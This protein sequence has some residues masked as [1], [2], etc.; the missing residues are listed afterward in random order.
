MDALRVKPVARQPDLHEGFAAPHELTDCHGRLP[1]ADLVVGD[2]HGGQH[3]RLRCAAAE[4]DGALTAEPVMVQ[5]NA[6]QVAMHP[7]HLRNGARCTVVD[8]AAVQGQHAEVREPPSGL[9][10]HP[11]PVR[12]DLVAR[13]AELLQSGGL[14]LPEGEAAGGSQAHVVSCQDLEGLELRK[15]GHEQLEP[16]VPHDRVLGDVQG[17]HPGFI[18]QPLRRGLHAARTAP[19]LLACWRRGL[20]AQRRAR[21][22]G[23]RVPSFGQLARS[24]GIQLIGA[25]DQGGDLPREARAALAPQREHQ[26]GDAAG[27]YAVLREVHTLA[28]VAQ[29]NQEQCQLPREVVDIFQQAL[30]CS[31]VRPLVLKDVSEVQRRCVPGGLQERGLFYPAPDLPRVEIDGRH[32]KPLEGLAAHA[33]QDEFRQEVVWNWLELPPVLVFVVDDQVPERRRVLED[34]DLFPDLASTEV[35]EAEVPDAR[36]LTLP[37]HGVE[38]LRQEA[39]RHV[40]RLGADGDELLVQGVVVATESFH[41]LQALVH[42]LRGIGPLAKLDAEERCVVARKREVVGARHPRQRLRRREVVEPREGLQAPA[43]AVV[44]VV[45]VAQDGREAQERERS[46]QRVCPAVV[47]LAEADVLCLRQGVDRL[48]VELHPPRGASLHS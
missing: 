47:A 32:C 44:V 36:F 3:P 8:R 33:G 19:G 25:Q 30:V 24:L 5:G 40:F 15:S 38:R 43:Q 34:S 22:F 37:G 41:V 42:K 10:D 1:R 16:L 26:R 45:H 18:Q 48:L 4:L 46:H 39:L 17:G 29:D 7:Q 11:G 13:E 28:L 20:R 31:Y 23:R 14:Q 6:P 2:V 27:V 21:I 12:P 9:G 35:P